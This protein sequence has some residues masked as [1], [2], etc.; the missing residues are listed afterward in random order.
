MHSLPHSTTAPDRRLFIASALG[1]A[2]AATA[3]GC[4]TAWPAPPRA[5]TFVLVH[6]AWC[7]GWCWSRV[8]PLLE[9][10]GARVFTPTLTGLGERQHLR[11]PVPGLQTHIQDVVNLIETEELQDVVLVGHSFAGMVI[12]PAADR[13]K[14]RLRRLVY[15]DAAVPAHG[16]DFATHVPGT[17]AAVAQRRRAAY[18]ALAPDGAW[19]PPPPPEAFGVTRQADVE[20]LRRRVSPHPLRSWLEP[21]ALPNGGHAGLPKTYVLAT[22]PLTT[23][24]GYPVHGEIARRGAEWTYREIATGHS[25]MVTAPERTAELLLEAAA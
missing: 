23:V 13:L 1:T 20:W 6:G 9:G 19:M 5:P 24:M 2:A 15:L 17:D 8:R 4:A 25:M 14:A 12:T 10:A 11:E 18:R 7:G 3:S 21:V 22:K 16:D